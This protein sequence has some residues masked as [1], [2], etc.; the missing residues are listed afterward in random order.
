MPD[1]IFSGQKK[2]ATC[3]GT[4]VARV[5]DKIR[6]LGVKLQMKVTETKATH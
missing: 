5:L 2:S 1:I 3:A 6:I 4:Y